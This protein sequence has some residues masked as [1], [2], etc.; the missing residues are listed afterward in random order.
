MLLTSSPCHKL[1]HI[2]GPSPPRACRTLWTAPGQILHSQSP[3]QTSTSRVHSMHKTFT[4]L[5]TF[6]GHTLQLCSASDGKCVVPGTHLVFAGGHLLS[7][8]SP[9]GI[10]YHLMSAVLSPRLPFSQSRIQA[11]ANPAMAP[12]RSCQWSLA[13][14]GAERVMI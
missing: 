5:L 7:P 6:Y 14:S 10:P 13:P 4:F 9:L 2:L 3:L 11:G 1:S 8:V 12:H